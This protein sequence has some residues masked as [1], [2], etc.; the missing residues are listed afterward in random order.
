MKFPNTKHL[1]YMI[2]EEIKMFWIT[3]GQILLQDF[4]ATR[5]TSIHN[6]G[7]GLGQMYAAGSAE[8]HKERDVWKAKEKRSSRHMGDGGNGGCIESVSAV[9]LCVCVP[10]SCIMTCSETTRSPSR[11]PL[12]AHNRHAGSLCARWKTQAYST[13]GNW[14]RR[15]Q[16]GWIH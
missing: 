1:V 3:S 8:R 7:A 5:I 12:R 10:S 14:T 11:R 2:L 6:S 13:Q 9:C 4:P 15:F 16:N